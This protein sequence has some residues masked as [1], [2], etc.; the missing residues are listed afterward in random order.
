[1][2]DHPEQIRTLATIHRQEMKAEIDH[3]RLA[4]AVLKAQQPA[5][6]H[7]SNKLGALGTSIS[8]L[9]HKWRRPT[10]EVVVKHG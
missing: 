4:T 5:H 1:M 9:V 2:F 3:W 8:Q 10:W 6:K 7:P